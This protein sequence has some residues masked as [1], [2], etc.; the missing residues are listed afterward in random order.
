[1][2]E[3]VFELGHPWIYYAD[4]PPV[5]F[6]IPEHPTLSLRIAILR[7]RQ[8]LTHWDGP[9]RLLSQ[10]GMGAITQLGAVVAVV[11]VG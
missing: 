7:P 11:I 1:M 2:G 8:S 5:T 10:D 4:Q 3:A 6:D 9:H